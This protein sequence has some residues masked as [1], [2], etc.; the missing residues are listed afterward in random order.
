M[1]L[2]GSAAEAAKLAYRPPTPEQAPW[3]KPDV[4]SKVKVEDPY[5]VPN[6]GIDH[7]IVSTQKHVADVEKA[8]GK[9]A[10][11]QNEDGKWMVPEVYNDVLK[12]GTPSEIAVG[13]IGFKAMAQIYHRSDPVCGSSGCKMSKKQQEYRQ[14]L[15]KYPDPDSMSFDQDIIDSQENEKKTFRKFKQHWDVDSG[16][17]FENAYQ[18]E[19]DGPTWGGGYNDD[20]KFFIRQYA[21]QLWGDKV[22]SENKK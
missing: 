11:K 2:F 14:S 16:E 21:K 8:K 17:D 7:D 22:E 4:G 13:P 15:P 3:H 10:P 1:M 20:S 18:M 9:W 5:F 19:R 6:F 12:P